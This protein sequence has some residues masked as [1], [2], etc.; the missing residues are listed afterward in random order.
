MRRVSESQTLHLS[1][2]VETLEPGSLL[3][4]DVSQLPSTFADWPL[5]NAKSF[6]ISAN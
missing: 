3:Q 2:L 6:H 5:A 1:D 4:E